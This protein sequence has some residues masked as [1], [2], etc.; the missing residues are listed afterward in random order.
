MTQIPSLVEACLEA[1]A[2]SRPQADVAALL[3]Q[4]VAQPAQLL[5]AARA[6]VA[7]D[8]RGL[9]VLHN[10]PRLTLMFVDLPAGFSTPPHD[11]G[12]WAAIC[13][14]EG[15]EEN[16]V[17]VERGDSLAL[18]A[19]PAADPGGLV[20]LDADAIHAIRNPLDQPLRALHAYGGDLLAIEHRYW[21]D[22]P[23]WD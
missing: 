22:F 13:V 18:V 4:A 14:T 20:L 21:E 17:Y 2:G 8:E 5:A 1:A 16:R 19:E 15:R 23:A 9:R 7:P 11:H 6:F 10:D 12:I 3:Q